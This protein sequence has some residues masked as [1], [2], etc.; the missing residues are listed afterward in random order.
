MM[1]QRV[2]RSSTY[3]HSKQKRH[4]TITRTCLFVSHNMSYGQY[5]W[6][7]LVVKEMILSTLTKAASEM[8]AYL[9]NS[10]VSLGHRKH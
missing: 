6:S 9:H 10:D 4:D 3:F 7:C 1:S 2:Q 8:V 5:L